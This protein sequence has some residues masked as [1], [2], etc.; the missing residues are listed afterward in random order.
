ML[1]H[2]Y[3]HSI[4]EQNKFNTIIIKFKFTILE[5]PLMDENMDTKYGFHKY[6]KNGLF[7]AT[8]GNLVLSH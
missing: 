5:A 6:V 1:K 8:L 2:K 7:L 3:I 4:L